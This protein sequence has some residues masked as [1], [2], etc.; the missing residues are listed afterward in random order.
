MMTAREKIENKQK[1]LNK[2]CEHMNTPNNNKNVKKSLLRRNGINFKTIQPD[3]TILNNISLNEKININKL[4]QLLNTDLINNKIV[5]GWNSYKICKNYY[6]AYDKENNNIEV[7]YTRKYNYGRVSPSKYLSV[8]IL[9]RKVRGTVLNGLYC[10]IDI[11][12]CNY[13]ILLNICKKYNYNHYYI[14]EYVNNNN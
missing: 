5:D 7:K 11:I 6:N 13:T 8:E 12:N 10:D 3:D 1:L 2:V 14:Q 9:K 4:E